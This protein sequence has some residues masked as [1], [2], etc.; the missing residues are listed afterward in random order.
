M[1]DQYVLNITHQNPDLVFI[2]GDQ[3]YDHKEHTAAWLKWGIQ[4]REIFRTRPCIVMPDD[5]DIGQGNLWGENGK[6]AKLGSGSDGGYVY[7]HE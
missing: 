2:A 7:H 3:S 1:R 4:F 5:H 6:I